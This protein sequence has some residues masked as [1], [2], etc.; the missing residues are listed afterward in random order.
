MLNKIMVQ[1]VGYS[2]VIKLLQTCK[3]VSLALHMLCITLFCM[4]NENYH[5][6]SWWRICWNLVTGFKGQEDQEGITHC[7]CHRACVTAAA[8]DVLDS[9]FIL[10]IFVWNTMPQKTPCPRK[11]YV[12]MSIFGICL[13]GWLSIR[14]HETPWVSHSWFDAD[15]CKL[16]VHEHIVATFFY[17]EE[18]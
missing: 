16:Q 14:T 18:L 7:C 4:K 2:L 10:F 1:D 5:K 3:Y 9:V 12:Q 11:H 8:T 17:L 13:L 15:T 6:G